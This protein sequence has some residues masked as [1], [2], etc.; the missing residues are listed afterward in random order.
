[1]GVNAELQTEKV[2]GQNLAS[3]VENISNSLIKIESLLAKLEPAQDVITLNQGIY[4]L[5]VVLVGALSAYFFNYLHWKMESKKN[6]L[7]VLSDALSSLIDEL[8]SVSVHY[9][10]MPYQSDSQPEAH[11]LEIKIKANRQLASKYIRLITSRLSDKDDG[12]TKKELE[13]FDQEMFE[14]ITGD[15]FESQSR[16]VS[17]P[18]AAEISKRCVSI[19]AAIV[20]L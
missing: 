5:F 15:G 4:G 3:S 9:W 2:I 20:M 12:L 11:A 19:K 13:D 16:E 1:V 18:K 10:L 7:S 6:K 14:I 8:E 17:K